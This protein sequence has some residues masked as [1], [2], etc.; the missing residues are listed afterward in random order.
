MAD[1]QSAPLAPR[2]RLSFRLGLNLGAVGLVGLVL[3]L[4]F[5]ATVVSA[6]FAALEDDD[7]EL[8]LARTDGMLAGLQANLAGKARDWA[9]W[10]DNYEFVESWDP[11]FIEANILYDA[12]FSYEVNAISIIR[13]DGANSL[14]NYYNFETE[15]LDAALSDALAAVITAPAFKD[16]AQR[17]QAFQEF[18]RVGDKLVTVAVNQVLRTDGS[19]PAQGYLVFATEVKADGL[20]EHLQVA[21]GVDFTL[22]ASEHEVTKD[23]DHVSVAVVAKDMDGAPVAAIRY[24]LPRNLMQAGRNLL[25]AIGVGVAA[26]VL[27]MIAALRLRVNAVVTAPLTAMEDHVSQASRSG[28]LTEMVDFHRDDEI[29]AL[30]SG[31]NAM[32]RQLAVL[33]ARLDQQSFELGK[34]QNRIDVM[35]N[36]R[37]GLSP[38]CTILSR[39]RDDLRAPLREN[40]DQALRELNDPDLPADR[41]DKLL[42][43]LSAALASHDAQIEQSRKLAEDAGANLLDVIGAIEQNQRGLSGAAELDVVE[44]Q[45]FLSANVSVARFS[46]SG[47]V[48]VDL[49]AA[50]ALHVRANRVLLAQVVGNVL[51]N[52]IES[53]RASG[54]QDGRITVD[55]ATDPGGDMLRISFADNGEGFDAAAR[56]QLFERGY[57]TRKGKSGGSGLHWSAN[58]INAMGGAMDIDSPGAGQGAT[59]TLSLPLHVSAAMRMAG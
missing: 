53:I 3:I 57:S 49:R 47:A 22:P 31:F 8:H 59:V 43:F 40:V 51:T 48:A 29:G 38:V 19:G 6:R 14:V 4:A 56:D 9:V 23:R 35:H 2:R 15:A 10:S 55:A 37:N 46:E 34:D 36:V 41:K 54:R 18:A 13:F 5:L 17:E 44:I 39:L 20:F 50:P 45:G 25:L 11:G 42:R 12:M 1:L 16:R 58:A 7:I 32:A 21:A 28:E 30:A 33:R 52:A 26:L 24:A 27:A